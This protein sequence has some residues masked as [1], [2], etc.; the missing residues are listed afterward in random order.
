M[1]LDPAVYDTLHVGSI[2]VAQAQHADTRIFREETQRK[3]EILIIVMLPMELEQ[4]KLLLL[5][6]AAALRN[7]CLNV[8][9]GYHHMVEDTKL[10]G[11]EQ[12]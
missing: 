12:L 6:A 3:D 1:D 11:R 8:R 4:V 10:G 9:L 7:I 2:E 5:Q